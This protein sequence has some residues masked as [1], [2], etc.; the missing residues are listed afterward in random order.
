M[1]VSFRHGQYILQ[2]PG[3]TGATK[4][5]E[6]ILALMARTDGGMALREILAQMEPQ[7]NERQL[8]DEL[9]VMKARGLIALTGHGRE[10]RWRR[11]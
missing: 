2:R 7:T 6:A 5:Q 9:A 8:R 1:T 3:I 10:S 4:K 11:L